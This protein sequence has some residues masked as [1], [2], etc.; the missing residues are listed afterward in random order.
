MGEIGFL[1]DGAG[2]MTLR[3]G[4]RDLGRYVYAGPEPQLESPR[5]YA[6]LGTLAGAEAC[7]YRPAD[8]VWHRG[9]SLALPNVGTANFWG[10]PTFVSGVGY[11]QLD[12]NGTQRHESFEPRGDGVVEQL[13]WLSADGAPLLT[14]TRTLAARLLDGRAWAL[15]WRSRLTSLAREP[16]AFGSPTTKGRPDAGYGGLFWRGPESF[17][18]GAIRC[19]EGRVD[20]GARG[21]P[22]DWLAFLAPGD[23]VGVLMLDHSSWTRPPWFV[24]SEEFAG[25]CP[26]PFFHDET[27]LG[28]GASLRLGAVVV[29][30]DGDPVGYL[31][32]ARRI[33]AGSG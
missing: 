10:G 11:V 12:N 27:V 3:A 9:L 22:H 8:H 31:A 5:P 24:R 30:A 6:M 14:E 1:D 7:G 2:A 21:R 25:L 15:T 32:R 13:T 18:G 26:A 17:T 19:A 23:T 20:D 33:R 29:L 4:S 16:L 28:P